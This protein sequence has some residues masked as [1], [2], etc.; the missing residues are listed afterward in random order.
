MEIWNVYLPPPP[1]THTQSK[2][3]LHFKYIHLLHRL[4]IFYS[5]ITILFMDQK[6][7]RHSHSRRFNI[8]VIDI[9]CSQFVPSKPAAQRQA[10]PLPLFWSKHVAPFWHGLLEHAGVS[11][12]TKIIK[13]V[14][15]QDVQVFKFV[16]SALKI[17]L[18][19]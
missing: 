6:L 15:L 8:C 13:F 18:M 5:A 14:H 9:P 4:R 2:D 1:H 3:S 11:M 16:R 7:L 10:Y 19:I 17:S 12:H